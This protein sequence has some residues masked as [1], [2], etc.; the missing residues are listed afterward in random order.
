MAWRVAADPETAVPACGRLSSGRRP[1][2]GTTGVGARPSGTLIG[3]R[4]VPTRPASR[5]LDSS[6]AVS[7]AM[8][9]AS[10]P[11]PRPSKK[12]AISLA[13]RLRLGDFLQHVAASLS[14][15]PP[16]P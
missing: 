5:L 7:S 16:R 9:S 15:D 1:C 4:A 8:A 10:C 2:A 3:S 13:L 11:P 12:R 14:G 6:I